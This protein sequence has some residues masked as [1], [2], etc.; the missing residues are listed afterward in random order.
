MYCTFDFKL[1]LEAPQNYTFKSQNGL[2]CN[3]F[4]AKMFCIKQNL[5]TESWNKRVTDYY[6]KYKNLSWLI[7]QA[8]RTHM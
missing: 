5:L 8:S 7:L 6:G 1:R 3:L 2:K 4:N